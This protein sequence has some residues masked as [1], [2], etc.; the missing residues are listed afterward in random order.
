[1]TPSQL[2]TRP[3]RLTTAGS[4]D[5][6]KSTLIGRLLYDS[7]AVLSDHVAA[8]SRS[9]AQRTAAGQLDLSLLTDGLEAE[10]E[11]GITIDVAYRYFATARRKFIIADA[12]GHEQYTR[13]MVTGA[14]NSDVAVILIDVTKLNFDSPTIELLP[15]TRRHAALADLLNLKAVVLAVNK[16]DALGY[17]EEVFNRV[18]DA[19]SEL[20]VQVK[21]AL[22]ANAVAVPVS[23]LEGDNVVEPSRHMPWYSG[24]TLLSALE[25][26]EIADGDDGAKQGRTQG[27]IAVQYVA[28]GAGGKSTR[29]YLGRV[30]EGRVHLGDSIT[31]LPS[32]TQA[33]IA[34]LYGADGPVDVAEQ[35]MNVSLELDR[36]LDV[37]RGDWLAIGAAPALTQTWQAEVAWLDNEPLAPGRR[38]WL[39][40]GHR[41]TLAKVTQVQSRLN[42]QTLTHEP[43]D[44][45]QANDIVSL[46]ITTQEALPVAPYA[47]YPQRGAFVLVDAASHRTVAAGMTT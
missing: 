33:R 39:R 37:S 12:P 25:T 22:L 8:V 6:G 13:N 30:E 11:Q 27:L 7:K 2:Q 4:V 19:F 17:R 26:L 31:V 38:Y 46:A 47:Q 15:Q 43:A 41:W 20:A 42:L 9:K 23:A 5:D 36:E 1:M 10:R 3:V 16:M 28:R 34:A 44:A 40:H 35:G 21:S 45:V 29:R 18:R 14:S 32:G 24:P